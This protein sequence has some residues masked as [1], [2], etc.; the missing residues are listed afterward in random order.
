MSPVSKY[1]FAKRTNADAFTKIYEGYVMN[2]YDAYNI[3]VHDFTEADEE[4]I[5]IV[6]NEN[7]K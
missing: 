6:N 4:R 5:K 2:F 3:A 1:T 7:R